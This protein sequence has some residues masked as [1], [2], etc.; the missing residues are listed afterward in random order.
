LFLQ[1]EELVKT[2]KRLSV[3]L[4]DELNESTPSHDAMHERDVST[5]PF[6]YQLDLAPLHELSNYQ[7][8][9]FK[10]SIHNKELAIR[11]LE[12]NEKRLKVSNHFDNRR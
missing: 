8:P 10:Q 5:T 4:D 2:K 7:T 11:S 9:S 6:N 12:F 1:S 3:F